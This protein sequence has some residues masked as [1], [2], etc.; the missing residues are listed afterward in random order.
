M[1]GVGF[2]A[3]GFDEGSPYFR[4]DISHAAHAAFI[5]DGIDDEIIGDFGLMPGGNAGIEV[6]RYSLRRGSP[7]DALVIASSRNHS[8]L[9]ETLDEVA[10]DKIDP[11]TGEDAVRADMVYFETPNGGAVFS[12]GSIAFAL[13][14]SHNAYFNNVSRISE[15]VLRHFIS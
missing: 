2:I 1:T 4:K 5:F 11:E 6:D 13:G 7:S 12:V 15:N 3:Q 10:P 8:P 14:L 9:Y